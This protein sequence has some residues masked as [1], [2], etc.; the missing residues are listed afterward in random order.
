M[1]S[2][3]FP[4][5][6]WKPT[7]ARPTGKF[8]AAAV[9]LM[10]GTAFLPAETCTTF[11]AGVPLGAVDF[12]TLKEASGLAASALNSGVVWTH[13]DGSGKKVFALN[14]NAQL[15]ARF[16][17]G[18]TVDDVEDIAVGPGPAVNTTYIYLADTGGR[19]E[20]SGFRTS[21]RIVRVPE[22]VVSP[23][24]PAA[25]P[26]TDFAGAQSFILTYPDGSFDAE[27]L[28]VDA[29]TS[30]VL[31]VTKNKP[32]SRLYRANLNAAAN[33][34][35]VPLTFVQTIPFGEPSGGDMSGDGS[36]ILLRNEDAALIWNR[37]AGE[38]VETA[39]SRPG[40]VAP[41]I[42]TPTEPNGEAITFM[43]DG[44]GYLTV[45][46]GENPLLYFFEATCPRPPAVVLPLADQSA[47]AGST[48]T[49][50]ARIS[51][52]PA[53]TF[54]W[55]LNGTPI[56]NQTTAT[57]T[58]TGIT[59]ASAGTYQVT[60]T[61]AG[62]FITD[63]AILTL[64]STLDLRVTELQPQPAAGNSNSGDWWELT[65]FE[66]APVSLAGWRFNDADGGLATAFTL[67]AGLT[68]APG[69]TLI[70]AETLTAAQFRTWWGPGVP[71]TARIITYTG[72]GLAFGAGGDSLRVWNATATADADTTLSV[73][74]G[75]AT[76]GVTFNYN[77]VLQQ[78]GGLSQPGVNGV[79]QAATAA[80][81]GS[82]GLIQIQAPA[83]DVTI[84][85]IP[86]GIRLNFTTQPGVTYHLEVSDDL[87]DPFSPTGDT[88][89]APDNAGGF[90]EKPTTA[91][92][93][94]Y[95]I[96]TS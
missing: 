27:A 36:Q 24:A 37:A 40:V 57:L 5:P 77:P 70:F 8:L 88:F 21:V 38:S 53:P 73:D 6:G 32:Q 80:D 85:P 96:R 18:I 22:P 86:T 52:S 62:G 2:S 66:A 35:T 42:G 91:P 54:A 29:V 64:R 46:E 23:T 78:F 50:T 72:A 41:V 39:L 47:A 63:D 56:P 30:D 76:S 51:G 79:F 4:D 20:P 71:A 90:F 61:N 11:A 33:G 15:L 84:T 26:S 87:T 45:S 19:A 81:I 55:T 13:N 14:L 89:T 82:P 58:L 59:A 93:R 83:P 25:P 49:F 94:F 7:S 34:A 12:T 10:A 75:A 69:E 44:S 95:R 48:V 67:P 16:D 74:F 28:L 3:P 17:T 1:K 43:R 65:S 9:A 92:R 68:I 60:A 31:V